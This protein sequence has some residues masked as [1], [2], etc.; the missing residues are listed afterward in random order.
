MRPSSNADRFIDIHNILDEFM[1]NL[2]QASHDMSYPEV[3]RRAAQKRPDI[4]RKAQTLK[5]HAQL[6]N[7]IIHN[8]DSR[9]QPIAE[10]HDHI[11]REYESLVERILRPP[12]ADEHWIPKSDIFTAVSSDNVVAAMKEM[13]TK[14]YSH[15]PILEEGVVVGVFS[16]WTPLE[17]V[18]D[19]GELL[20]DDSQVFSEFTRW[21]DLDSDSNREAVRFAKRD[22]LLDEI[23]EMIDRD[24]K[25]RIRVGMV[26]FT[27]HGRRD[28]RLL[29]LI[30]PWELLNQARR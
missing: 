18:N 16:E 28:E 2:I 8:S 13:F 14:R 3:V 9:A 6:R 7:A 10:P 12:K 5:S 25:E 20:V 4:K 24:I 26:L 19:K 29:G 17:I 22:S 30:T 1:R 23:R 21:T 15:V 11:V 27:E